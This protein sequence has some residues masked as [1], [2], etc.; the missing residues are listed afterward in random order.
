ML[1]TTVHDPRDVREDYSTLPGIPPAR[2][3]PRAIADRL[4]D[5][6]DRLHRTTGRRA[7]R[8]GGGWWSARCPGPLH[9]HRDRSPSL[10][11]KAGNWRVLV[12]C[13]AGCSAEAVADALGLRMEDLGGGR[14]LPARP[15]A[16]RRRR[17]PD[18]PPVEATPEPDRLTVE[19]LAAA[20]GLPLLELRSY[21]LADRPRGKLG[22]AIPYRD[23]GGELV[24]E[25]YRLR[26]A[27]D[28]FR[29]RP[30]DA[31]RPYG[32]DRL[33][34]DRT[35]AVLVVEGESDCWVAWHAGIPA[36]GIPGAS[37]WNADAAEALA[38]RPVVVVREPGDSGERFAADAAE[39]LGD[40]RVLDAAEL[41]GAK[42]LRAAWDRCGRDLAAFRA[43]V[44]EA[45]AAACP[46]KSRSSQGRGETPSRSEYRSAR[47]GTS[48]LC[49]DARTPVTEADVELAD[50]RTVTRRRVW[51][52]GCRRSTCPACQPY[53][54]WRQADRLVRT[55]AG[56][57]MYA[58]E[59]ADVDWE[60]TRRRVRRQGGE[61][62]SVPAPGG[63][64]VML[65]TVPPTVAA[66]AIPEE[67]RQAEA[68]RITGAQPLGGGRIRGTEGFLAPER[69]E[70][71]D[72][73]GR[74]VGFAG[75]HVTAAEVERLAAA[76]R[77]PARRLTGPPAAEGVQL[78][79]HPRDPRVEWVMVRI[80]YTPF[81]SEEERRQADADLAAAW[82]Q[83][84]VLV[85]KRTP[86]EE[87]PAELYDQLALT[88]GV[89][90]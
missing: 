56:R 31:L 61:Y 9:R 7:T 8:A 26:L 11:V 41:L 29:W 43:L 74:V 66:E 15:A 54:R 65:A 86:E 19:R 22:V 63:A 80:G 62:A 75:R 64:R 59:V 6:L 55:F 70:D 40:V 87:P 76:A 44:A 20:V 36:L 42:D 12:K 67:R 82:D 78:D 28:R 13:H 37:A 51:R 2:P 69:A 47:N 24:A 60:A 72:K 21:G 4:N 90:A 23:A 18:R 46:V 39:L 34:E 25:R 10:G 84:P 38:G 77:L 32:L 68:E 30:G 33:P 89:A 1:T 14:S 88:E 81:R 35:V 79:A 53:V 48:G 57:P 5:V 16:A 27:G 71:A 52:V 73:P 17:E 3:D 58:A 45:V 50:G 49:P 85:R 83:D